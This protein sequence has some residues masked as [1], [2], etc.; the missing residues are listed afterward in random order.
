MNPANG[1]PPTTPPS[2]CGSSS[3]DENY[4]ED[5]WHFE[6]LDQALAVAFQNGRQEAIDSFTERMDDRMA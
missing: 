1:Y 3:C 4:P 5:G 2:G 6:N